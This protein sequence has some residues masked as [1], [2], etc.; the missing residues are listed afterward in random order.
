[1]AP[2]LVKAPSIASFR[3]SKI[4]SKYI[5]LEMLSYADY[6]MRAVLYLSLSCNG[7]RNISVRNFNVVQ[8]IFVAATNMSIS[9]PNDMY[10][11]INRYVQSKEL[12]LLFPN[13]IA[14]L[15]E[16]KYLA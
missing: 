5:I 2:E 14:S 8:K 6:K 11:L 15:V 12:H 3:L 7:M 4:N 9:L 1:M 13:R 16:L 10:K